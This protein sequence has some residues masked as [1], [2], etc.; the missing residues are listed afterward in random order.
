MLKEVGVLYS[1]PNSM[2]NSWSTFNLVLLAALTLPALVHAQQGAIG[3]QGKF[4]GSTD[5]G[6][7]LK[8]STVYNAA[9]G[10]YRI[11]GSGAD[12]WGAAD[13]FHLNWIQLAGD[14]ALTADVHFP[15]GPVTPLEKG[16]LIMRQ[17]LDPASPYA[18]VAIHG[19]GHITLQYRSA[20][21]GKTEDTTS[22]EHG[23]VRLRIERKGNVFTAYN[24]AADGKLTA[25]ASTT[26]AM[27]GPIY[28]GL[29]VCAHDANALATLTFS[30]V[31]IE[32]LSGSR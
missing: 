8:G 32:L 21:G 6:A 23:S 5:V 10:S 27:E 24:L 19:D 29:G 16:V 18:D 11:T 13:A 2:K 1:D 30:N 31:T 15:L 28:V 12:M 9:N 4:S 17:S 20:A 22:T 7:T 3:A 26:I 25:F 14:A